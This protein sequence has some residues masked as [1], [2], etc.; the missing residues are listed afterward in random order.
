MPEFFWNTEGFPYEILRDIK[1]ST[2]NRD[3]SLL[4]PPLFHKIFRYQK[5]SETRKGSTQFLVLWDNSSSTENRDTPSPSPLLSIK[6]FDTRIFP[7]HRRVPYGLRYWEAKK[8]TKI[9][10]PPPLSLILN[11]FGYQKHKSHP[12]KIF[13]SVRQIF[14]WRRIVIPPSL[15]A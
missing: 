2:E 10:M 6:F 7:K 5:L 14:F 13:G 1:F 4:R 11:F 9:V 12:T 3:N 8:S 15:Y